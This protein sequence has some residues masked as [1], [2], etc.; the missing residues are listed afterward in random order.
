[1]RVSADKGTSAL[2]DQRSSDEAIEVAVVLSDGL[3]ARGGIG[4][5]VAY[6]ARAIAAGHPDIRLRVHR[7]RLT[8]RAVAKHLSVPF[9]LAAFAARIRRARVAHVNIA[10]RGSTW[11][12]ALYVATARRMGLR[13][14]LHLHGSGYD[15]FYHGL[16]PARQ[17]RVRRLFQGAD[18]VVALGRHWRD[19]VTGELGVD[20]AR[21]HQIANGVPSAP[22]VAPR[23]ARATPH[24]LFLGALGERKG[25]DVLLDA[26]A[27][28]T[29]RGI[30]W[31]ATL[32]GNGA[33]AE[34]QARA[35]A[36][37]IAGD[38]AFPG[39]VDEA[40]VDALLRDADVFVL[41]SRAENQ[42]VAILE[43]MARGVPVVASAIGAIPEQ[44]T[45]GETG[46]LVPPGDAGALAD[47][48]AT[49]LAAPDARAAM[50]A[51]G[52][53]R[54]AR[55]YAIEACAAK[56]AGLYRA[57]AQGGTR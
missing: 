20:A 41:P 19:F 27:E 33:V 22:A 36:A 9:A 42:P 8:E 30:A 14:L 46:L 26:L 55:D 50:G 53:A 37:G 49:L 21:V 45:D 6:L 10:P 31:R 54:F 34:A 40:A 13:T 32:G 43:A 56:F 2:S 1:M 48:F 7:A 39:W 57:L 47:A 25:T 4:R 17:A 11:R 16:P 12:K 29:R 24:I 28:L 44:I 15:A 5:V 3:S 38:I 51:A 52:R 18:A 23:P 35:A